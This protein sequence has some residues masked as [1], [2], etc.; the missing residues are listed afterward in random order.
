MSSLCQKLLIGTNII[1]AFVI[2]E[3]NS[4]MKIKDDYNEHLNTIIE[5]QR[6]ELLQ[7]RPIEEPKLYALNGMGEWF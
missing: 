7:Y 2:R 5:S 3:M 6:K 1:S 4:N